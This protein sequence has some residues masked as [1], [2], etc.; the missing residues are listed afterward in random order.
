MVCLSQ[1]IA[2]PSPYHWAVHLRLLSVRAADLL[3]T[4]LPDFLVRGRQGQ[5]QAI[6]QM[7]KA[8]GGR[9]KKAEDFLKPGP[10]GCMQ[11]S[12]LQRYC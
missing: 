12:A 8:E 7:R 3:Q 11:N 10:P 5:N 4:S 2:I 6:P 1:K 9:H